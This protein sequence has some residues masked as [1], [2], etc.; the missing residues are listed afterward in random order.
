MPFSIEE[1]RPSKLFFSPPEPRVPQGP[2][3]QSGKDDDAVAALVMD[4]GAVEFRIWERRRR[5]RMNRGPSCPNTRAVSYTVRV[6]KIRKT[7]SV[8]E[9]FQIFK[10]LTQRKPGD[11]VV[12]TELQERGPMHR[13]TREKPFKSRARNT[14]SSLEHGLG[15]L[16][17]ASFISPP[18]K[19]RWRSVNLE[20]TSIRGK[21]PIYFSLNPSLEG[22]SRTCPFCL[23]FRPLHSLPSLR[24]GGGQGSRQS[25][26][27]AGWRR[28]DNEIHLLPSPLPPRGGENLLL[29][30]KKKT[31][32]KLRF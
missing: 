28:E 9:F 25:E 13:G 29:H 1:K 19:R 14:C 26:G 20:S 24:R 7:G 2:I 21:T 17:S 30:G 6:S 27:R 12:T 31:S 4:D 5:R 11:F 32:Q 8:C 23:F 18:K 10:Q 15:S 16:S 22:K 3:S